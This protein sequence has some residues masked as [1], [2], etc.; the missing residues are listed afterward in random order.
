MEIAVLPTAVGPTSMV[1]GFVMVD[2]TLSSLSPGEP[3]MRVP[4]QEYAVRE[5]AEER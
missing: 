4:C 3:R 1:N 5:K 2:P